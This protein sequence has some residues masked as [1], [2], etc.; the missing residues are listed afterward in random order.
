VLG[1]W[2]ALLRMFGPALALCLVAQLL[3]GFLVHQRSWGGLATVAPATPSLASL[4]T[5]N[6]VVLTPRR[7]TG[8]VSVSGVGF[9]VPNHVVTLAMS[10]ARTLAVVANLAAL[11]WFGMWMGLNSKSS[12]FATLKTIVFVEV[13]PWFVVMFASALLVPLILWPSLLGGVSTATSRIMVWYPL[14]TSGLV[15]LLVVVKDI[16]FYL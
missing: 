16:A 6:T 7:A 15:T 11:S 1:H 3:G 8:I 10:A 9:A 13:I 12:N 14:L 5:T 2:R 4:P